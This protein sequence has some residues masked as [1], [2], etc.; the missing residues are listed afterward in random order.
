MEKAL[1][2]AKLAEKEG[3]VP[4]GCVI[5]KNEKIIASSYNLKEKTSNPIGHCEILALEQ[6]GKKLNNWRLIDCD[7]YVTLEPCIMCA[8]AIL[9]SRISNVFFGCFDSKFGGF[10]SL[11]N[12][13]EDSRLN[14]SVNVYSELLKSDCQNLIQNFFRKK[15]IAAKKSN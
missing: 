4:I 5:T 12:F 7:I 10:G 14:H 3:E 1:C 15:R 2:N 11:Y 6:A 8:G 13:H 9:H